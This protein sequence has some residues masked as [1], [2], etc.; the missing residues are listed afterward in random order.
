VI[1]GR[2]A[3]YGVVG[4]PVGHSRSPE[5]HNPAFARLGIDAV[6][7]ALPVPPDGL[8][9]ALRGAH[10]LGF[11][12]L[13]VTV[14]HK[15]RALPLCLVVDEVAR[16]VGAVNTLRRAADGWEGFNTD[17][18]AARSLL[19]GAG[20]GRGTRA[21]LL[22]A[23]GVARAAAWALLELGT[24]LR[25]MARRPE[26]AAELVA[27][28]WPGRARARPCGVGF[29]ALAAEVAAA[30]AVLNA[31]T[32]GLHGHEDRFAGLAFRRGQVAVDF[33][34]GR[35]PFAAAALEAGARLVSGE[36]ILVRQGALAFTLW[37]G[38]AAPEAEMATALAGPGGST[39]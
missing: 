36:A 37:T 32:V 34:Y 13:N 19:D 7:V 14:P 25:V 22:G 38:R 28:L 15:Q 17:A 12:G 5:M 35:T 10:A 23:G 11:R 6:Y 26:A 20:V 2:T 16:Q 33:V 27:S 21:L 31:T 4:H 24:D 39:P 3:L 8:A 1:T 30:D 18:L 29:G 9:D